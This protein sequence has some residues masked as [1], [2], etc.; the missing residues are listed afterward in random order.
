MLTLLRTVGLN[1]YTNGGRKVEP[2]RGI[3]GTNRS[4][5]VLVFMDRLMR[6]LGVP[7][8]EVAVSARSREY[9]PSSSFTACVHDVAIGNVDMWCAHAHC[10]P[11]ASGVAFSHLLTVHMLF[12]I[13]GQTFGPRRQGASS[14]PSRVRS[15][16]MT[17]I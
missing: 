3:G 14:P 13:A 12:C 9:S 15:T 6:R 4:G 16:P 8:E 1:N 17:S 2:F 5:S 11:A 7:W 10:H